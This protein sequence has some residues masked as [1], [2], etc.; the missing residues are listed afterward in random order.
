MDQHKIKIAQAR[1]GM[2][3][4][5]PMAFGATVA[6]VLGK[7]CEPTQNSSQYRFKSAMVGGYSI[8]ERV[9]RETRRCHFAN[10]VHGPQHGTMEVDAWIEGDELVV[11]KPVGKLKPP[12]TRHRENTRMGFVEGAVRESAAAVS[13]STTKAVGE[14]TLQLR[15]EPV[16]VSVGQLAL[17]QVGGKDFLFNVPPEDLLGVAMEWTTKGY[18]VAS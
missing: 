18:A 2:S 9:D 8:G 5:F 16:M 14:V 13:T 15:T 3:L 7:L 11:M 1:S 4:Y 12:I 6:S 10:R 17:L